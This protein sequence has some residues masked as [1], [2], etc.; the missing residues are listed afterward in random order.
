MQ[1]STARVS[2]ETVEPDHGSSTNFGFNSKLIDHPRQNSNGVVQKE[3]L[4][5]ATDSRW[6]LWPDSMNHSEPLAQHGAKSPRARILYRS[7]LVY[8]TVFTKDWD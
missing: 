6:T 4:A 5:I 7:K 2:A 8:Q 1:R 3:T